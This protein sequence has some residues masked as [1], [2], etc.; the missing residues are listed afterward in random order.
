MPRELYSNSC[1]FLLINR[2]L[3]FDPIP[4]A[5]LMVQ[6]GNR[7]VLSEFHGAELVVAR[8]VETFHAGP[9]PGFLGLEGCT[10]FAVVL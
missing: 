7:Q 4:L 1:Y 5:M 3:S 8:L 6:F 10:N 2:S 9:N